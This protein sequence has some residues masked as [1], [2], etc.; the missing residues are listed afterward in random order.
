MERFW[1][2]KYVQQQDMSEIE[3]TVFKDNLVRADHLPHGAASGGG[4]RICHALRRV[5][6]RPGRDR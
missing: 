5:R 2:L 4:A 6:V 3:A 1:T